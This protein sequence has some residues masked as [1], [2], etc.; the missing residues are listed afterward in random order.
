MICYGQKNRVYGCK[1]IMYNIHSFM[2]FA[3]STTTC[4]ATEMC[5]YIYIYIYISRQNIMHNA[6]E[7]HLFRF[8]RQ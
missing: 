8:H 2:Q 5:I 1:W 6:M 7:Q 3:T 4:S